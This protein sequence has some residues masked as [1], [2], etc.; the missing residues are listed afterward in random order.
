MK[1]FLRS[2]ALIVWVLYIIVMM[3]AA[4]LSIL[5]ID[6]IIEHPNQ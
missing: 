4:I 3:L 6:H 1:K 5:Y 2:I